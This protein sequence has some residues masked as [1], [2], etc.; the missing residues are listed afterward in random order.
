MH[1][2]HIVQGAFFSHIGYFAF[3]NPELHLPLYFLGHLQHGE[4]LLQLFTEGFE[5]YY[6]ELLVTGKYQHGYTS[7]FLDCFWMC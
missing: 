4:I 7:Y 2:L 3:K 6:Q 5:F 1:Y